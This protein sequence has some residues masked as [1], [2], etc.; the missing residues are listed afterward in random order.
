MGKVDVSGFRDDCIQN[1]IANT[2]ASVWKYTSSIMWKY[3]YELFIY[4]ILSHE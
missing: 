1:N 2:L 4:E 3:D